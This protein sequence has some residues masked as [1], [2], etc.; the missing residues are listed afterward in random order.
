MIE[1][2]FEV[3]DITLEMMPAFMKERT[4]QYHRRARRLDHQVNAAR[5]PSPKGVAPA[6][7]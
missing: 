7:R 3:T 1:G 4:P 6:A 2:G 5:G